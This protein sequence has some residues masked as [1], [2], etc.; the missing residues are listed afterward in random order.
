MSE[1]FKMSVS[2]C[3][4]IIYMRNVTSVFHVSTRL[5]P[6]QNMIPVCSKWSSWSERILLLRKL[7]VLI[8]E[9]MLTPQML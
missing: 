5:Y 7:Q 4:T 6:Y 9:E 3:V 1:Y 2:N 8:P